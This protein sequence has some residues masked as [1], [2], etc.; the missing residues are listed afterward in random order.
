MNLKRLWGGFLKFLV[1][2]IRSR[3]NSDRKNY[4]WGRSET[5]LTKNTVP[6]PGHF[7]EFFAMQKPKPLTKEAL[8]EYKNQLPKELKQSMQDIIHLYERVTNKENIEDL[9]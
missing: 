6:K 3:A 7:K 8:E 5:S 9:K 2:K 4:T 1:E